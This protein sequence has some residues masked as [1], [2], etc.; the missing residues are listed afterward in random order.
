MTT[1]RRSGSRFSR[2]SKKKEKPTGF[3]LSIVD[4]RHAGREYHFQD[5]A[6]L[7]RVEEADVTIIDPGISRL[8][9]R[10]S[11]RRGVFIV[12]DMGS[13]NGTRLNG[14]IIEEPEVLRDGDY[15]TVGTVNVMFSNLELDVSGEATARMRLTEKQ[16]RKLDF[17]EKR[18]DVEIEL[19]KHLLTP[20]RVAVL[21]VTLLCWILLAW[22]TRRALEL[23]LAVLLTGAAFGVLW[24]RFKWIIAFLLEKTP[25]LAG[26]LLGVVVVSVLVGLFVP[27][28]RKTRHDVE[29][30]SYIVDY[31]EYRRNGYDSWA[32]GYSAKHRFYGD[33][34]YRDKIVFKYYKPR[35]RLRVTLEYSV[36]GVGEEEVAVLLNGERVAFM[37]RVEECRYNLKVQLPAKKLKEGDNLVTLDNLRNGPKGTETWQISYVVFRE[38]AIPDADPVQASQHFRLGMSL[39]EER[40]VNP[41]NRQKAVKHF[42]LARD[43]L[44]TLPKKP[45]NYHESNRMIRLIDKQLDKKFKGAIFE[46][47]R[48]ANYGKFDQARAVLRRAATYF[49]AD[50][51][52]PRLIKL[53][54]AFDQLSGQ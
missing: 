28:K 34:N 26:A 43:F 13:A 25:A 37:P 39:Y 23:T 54:Q 36:C 8:H 49:A 6:S 7:G 19:G 1:P 53:S 51:K 40:E 16:A 10:V 20:P 30:S 48:R 44:E 50:R 14:E 18:E 4:G 42:K 29:W 15:I 52:D 45:Q 21:G 22:I 12:E 17:E 3:I 41:G 9:A 31:E 38:E 27:H 47:Q 35:Q 5:E 46:A 24:W 11:G 33:Q 32:M 2:S